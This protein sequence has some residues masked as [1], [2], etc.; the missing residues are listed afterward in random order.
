[1]NKTLMNTVASSGQFESAVY[2]YI[3]MTNILK[4][5][6]SIFKHSLLFTITTQFVMMM[7]I[8]YTL[9]L[10]INGLTDVS[11]LMTASATFWLV[12]EFVILLTL[13]EVCENNSNEV[14]RVFDSLWRLSPKEFGNTRNV[15]YEKKLW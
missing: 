9:F 8:S 4:L 7:N 12:F 15:S 1:M 11:A 6:S 14:I 10:A 2:I 5:L 13:I 3:E